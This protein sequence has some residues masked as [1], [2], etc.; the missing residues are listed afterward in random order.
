MQHHKKEKRPRNIPPSG[1]HKQKERL[2]PT[3]A[4]TTPHTPSQKLSARQSDHSYD[5]VTSR[6]IV[7]TVD[8]QSV[9]SSSSAACFFGSRLCMLVIRTYPSNTSS[10]WN[11]LAVS[12]SYPVH[13]FHH[14]GFHA[15][16][17][18]SVTCAHARDT[19]FLRVCIDTRAPPTTQSLVRGRR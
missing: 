16:A 11:Y 1:C 2:H 9:L 12:R 5:R 15:E 17:D 8:R 6:L 13:V 19:S 10:H 7:R 14:V 3:D 18:S 4:H